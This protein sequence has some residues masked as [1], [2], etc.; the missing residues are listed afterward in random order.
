MPLSSVPLSPFPRTRHLLVA[1][2][3]AAL[4]PGCSTTGPR[5]STTPGIDTPPAWARSELAPD[6]ALDTAA[7]ASWW[8]RFDDPVLDRLVAEALANNPDVRI[9]VSRIA[10]ARANRTVERSALLPSLGAGVSGRGTRTRDHR[11]DAVTEGDTYSASLDASWEIDL[12]GKNRLGL[13]AA[14]ADFS[15]TEENLRAAQVSL[16]AEVALTYVE[17]RSAEVQLDV[18]RRSL[19]SREETTRLTRWRE[20]AGVG[21]VLDTRQAENSLEQARASLPALEQS[22]S[23]T[24]NALAVLCGRTPGSLDELLSATGRVP[25]PPA[26]LAV[27]IPAE[28]LRQRPDVRAAAL[29]VEAAA[30]RSDAARRDRLPTLKLTGSLGVDAAEFG[31]LAN[32]ASTVASLAGGLTAPIFNAGRIGANIRIQDENTLQALVSYESAVLDALAEVENALEAV[33]RQAERHEALERAAAAA[34]E[35]DALA[36]QQYEAGSVDFLRVLDAERSLLSAEQSLATTA[37]ALSSAHIRLYKAL[38]GGWSADT[39]ASSDAGLA[40]A[41]APAS[42]TIDTSSL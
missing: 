41:D 40:N 13:A 5:P 30:K 2:P 31:K 8:K 19:A 39:D 23:E 38:G 12:F 16:A 34:R 1:L 14:D 10:Q 21:D 6:G 42:D 33:R 18:V 11:T 7:L 36:R 9:A 37:A 25:A 3:L 24:R 20:Q 35:A 28:T 4:L 17:L 22:L 15:R 26:A 32:P 29:A 27:G